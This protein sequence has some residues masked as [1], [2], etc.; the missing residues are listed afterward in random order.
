[1]TTYEVTM[2]LASGSLDVEVEFEDGYEPTDN[3]IFFAAIEVI[4]EELSMSKLGCYR[5][6]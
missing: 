5:K 4:E 3:E 1:M 6:R 2:Q